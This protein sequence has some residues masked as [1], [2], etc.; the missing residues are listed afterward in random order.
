LT[1]LCP[2][3][4]RSGRAFSSGHDDL[5]EG[6]RRQSSLSGSFILVEEESFCNVSCDLEVPSTVG[7]GLF[8]R[9]S[10]LTSVIRWLEI[11]D[12]LSSSWRCFPRY[13]S[14][15]PKYD[16]TRKGAAVFSR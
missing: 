4:R 16:R 7:P 8:N 2:R 6:V 12:K 9:L 1:L 10:C 13:C 5:W 3:S 14:V 11:S 15:V